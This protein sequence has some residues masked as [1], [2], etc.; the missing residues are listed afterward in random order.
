ML[1]K[2]SIKLFTTFFLCLCCP[3]LAQAQTVDPDFFNQTWYLYEIFDSDT[4]ET[5]TVE[6]YQPYGGN[7]EIE[8]INPKITIDDNLQ[9]L[10]L[11]IC[12]TISGTLEKDAISGDF[13]TITTDGTSDACG[14]FEDMDEPY[15]FGPFANIEPDPLLYTIVDPTVTTNSDGFQ[16]MTYTTQPFLQYTYRNTPVLNTPENDLATVAIYPNPAQN[17]LH[18]QKTAT[19][20]LALDVRIISVSGQLVQTNRLEASQKSLNIA[21]L[22]PGLYFVNISE[23]NKSSTHKLIVR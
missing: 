9:F 3:F 20:E 15:I 22:A 14:F 1:I 7:P 2:E 12:N 6:G 16:T 10:G 18:F 21:M 13:R 19:T 23:G 4:N 8:Q 11:G 5:F 17:V